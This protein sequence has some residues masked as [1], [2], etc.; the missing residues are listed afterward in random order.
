MA[1]LWNHP[2]VI[3]W[4]LSN[5]SQLDNAWEEGPFQDFVNTRDA[6]RP[7]LRT[8]ST[9]T[10][11]NYDVHHCVNLGQLVSVWEITILGRA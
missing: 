11:E 6:T 1:W 9:G 10:K 3:M 4:A 8:G 5:E 2:A 7:T